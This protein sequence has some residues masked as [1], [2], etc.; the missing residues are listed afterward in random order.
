M[1]KRQKIRSNHKSKD[2]LF[3]RG[4]VL[5]VSLVLLYL[6]WIYRDTL[7][8]F[9]EYG[10]I[11][12]FIINFISAATVFLPAPGTASVFIGGAVWNPILVGIISGA[13]SAFG[14]LFA[15][16]LGYGGRGLLEME[17]GK[18]K[19]IKNLEKS[20]LKSGFRTTFIFAAIPIPFFDIIGVIAGAAS[21]SVW[22]FFLA[23]CS[24]R[25][26]RNILFAFTG[27]KIFS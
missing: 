27:D 6:I 16:F 19:W 18:H 4:T 14:E 17:G 12:I 10:Y 24:A 21:Y 25:I 20:F 9:S 8:D 13:G 11:G 5:A 2:G 23:V 22:K 7:R 26:L 3:F 1:R 15:Y